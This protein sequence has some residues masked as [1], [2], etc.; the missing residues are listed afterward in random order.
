LAL[1]DNRFSTQ[2]KLTESAQIR[3]VYASGSR[4]RLGPFTIFVLVNKLDNPRICI[5]IAKKFIAKATLRNT[6]KRL[7]RENFRLTKTTIQHMDI[8]ITVNCSLNKQQLP[9]LKDQLN[10][11][12]ARLQKS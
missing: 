10:K 1:S 9:I 12:W 8:V 5:S 3:R 7:I 6:I 2:Y 11:I 4:Y